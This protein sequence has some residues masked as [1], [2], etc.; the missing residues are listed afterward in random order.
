MCIGVLLNPCEFA[1]MKA[2]R[3]CEERSKGFEFDGGNDVRDKE[4]ALEKQGDL[5]HQV[6]ISHAETVLKRLRLQYA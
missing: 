3:T 5:Q 2:T 6:L 1:H 4:H